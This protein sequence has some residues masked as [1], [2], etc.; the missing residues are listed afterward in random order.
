MVKGESERKTEALVFSEVSREGLARRVCKEAKV[1]M[2]RVAVIVDSDSA[3]D[4][5]LDGRD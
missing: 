1:N 2:Y 5:R 4:L 3:Y